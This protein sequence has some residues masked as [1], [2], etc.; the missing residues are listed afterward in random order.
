MKRIFVF[1]AVTMMGIAVMP[2]ANA[3]FIR[4]NAF[5][6]PLI[7]GEVAFVQNDTI[8]AL[9]ADDFY[10]IVKAWVDQNYPD[11]K[12]SKDKNDDFQLEAVVHFKIDDQYIHAPLYYEGTLHL[13]WKDE[14]IQ[15]KLDGLNYT[16]GRLNGKSNKRSGATNVSFKVK[17]QVLSGADKSYPHTWDSLNDYAAAMLDDFSYTLREAAKE[18][19]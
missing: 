2:T 15:I 8:E 3:Q 10:P 14:V 18:I 19:L 9:Y 11:A 6:L 13:K 7:N 17:Q 5:Q 16:P 12:Y 4:E 1:I